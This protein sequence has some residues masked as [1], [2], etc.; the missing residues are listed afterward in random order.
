MTVTMLFAIYSAPIL[1][2]KYVTT[3]DV[4]SEGES[5]DTLQKAQALLEEGRLD[6][7]LSTLKQYWLTNPSDSAAILLFSR[8]MSQLDNAQLAES[9]SR[10][11]DLVKRQDWD[12]PM[13][14]L[15]GRQV[16]ETAYQ[17]IDLRL[18]DL[19]VMLMM[20]CL[21][22]APN[23]PTLNYE[24]GFALMALGKY[25]EA[26]NHFDTAARDNQD[27]DTVLNLA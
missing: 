11:A 6:Y 20:R 16:F 3:G 21:D 4:K 1:E 26:I 18:Y 23:D 12:D 25:D 13:G 27:F 10:L 24:L 5:S 14:E 19:A 7:C 9:L 17:L 15:S 8:L 22:E 2:I